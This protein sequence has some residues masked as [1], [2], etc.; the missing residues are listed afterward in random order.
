MFL[1]GQD[2]SYISIFAIIYYEE[3]TKLE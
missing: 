3:I 2:S 1:I